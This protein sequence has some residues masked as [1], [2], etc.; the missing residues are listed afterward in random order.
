MGNR[1]GAE[2]GRV[3]IAAVGAL[4]MRESMR[5]RFRPALLDLAAH[6]DV[7]LLAGDLTNGGTLR[8]TGTLCAEI[9]DLPVP[10][11]AVLG[12]HDHDRRLGF[13]IS[14][15]L[16]D[17]GVHMLDGTAIT[18]PVNGIRLGIAGVMGGS[19]G[20]PG[21]PGN[22][23]EGSVEHRQRF[24][25]GPADALRLRAALESLDC[26]LRVALMH[27][28]PVVDTLVGEAPKIYPGLGCHDLADAVE[29]GRAALALHGHAH[30]GTEFGRTPGGVEVRNVSYPVIRSPYR[31]YELTHPGDA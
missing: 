21:H 24:R 11:I 15:R 26:D 17:L 20:F 23:A 8:D 28:S 2:A 29:T 30:G 19:G 25:R 14:V 27:F 16:N 12:N 7:L 10:V 4:H 13:R 1:V 9:A 31:V 6:A 3:R 22:P 5:G 18:L